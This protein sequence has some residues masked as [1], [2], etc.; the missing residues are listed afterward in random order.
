[1]KSKLLDVPQ[2]ATMKTFRSVFI[3]LTI[4]TLSRN[5]GR[6]HSHVQQCT[7]TVL[8]LTVEKLRNVRRSGI[9]VQVYKQLEIDFIK[10]VV[11]LQNR[12]FGGD[13]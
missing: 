4:E 2:I 13:A 8:Y 6:V 12:Y 3:M 1:M 9:T 5:V 11:N 10:I 7:G